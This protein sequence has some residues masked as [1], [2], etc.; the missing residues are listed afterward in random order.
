MYAICI[1]VAYCILTPKH[2]CIRLVF[3][4]CRNKSIMLTSMVRMSPEFFIPFMCATF[5]SSFKLFWGLLITIS[6]RADSD[7]HLLKKM[8]KVK[9]IFIWSFLAPHLFL[10]SFIISLMVSSFCYSSKYN[11]M[12]SGTFT[13]KQFTHA[14]HLYFWNAEPE[15][16]WS[17]CH[18][19][20]ANLHGVHWTGI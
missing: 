3:P 19:L 18:D 13:R 11:P 14:I 2:I 1:I 4:L 8:L 6:H 5:L 17:P 12:L 15:S 9:S 16:F 20:N 7:I 10:G